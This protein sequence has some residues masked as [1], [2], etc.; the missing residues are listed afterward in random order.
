[1]SGLC[2]ECESKAETA[3]DQVLQGTAPLA[4]VPSGLAAWWL[5]GHN[6]AERI[7]PYL[8]R[9]SHVLRGWGLQ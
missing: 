6:N 5:A 9:V 3:L 2:Q 1:M 7:Q 8:D 4:T